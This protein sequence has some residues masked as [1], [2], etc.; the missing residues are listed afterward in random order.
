MELFSDGHCRATGAWLAPL[1]PWL[2]ALNVSCANTCTSLFVCLQDKRQIAVYSRIPPKASLPWSWANPEFVPRVKLHLFDGRK[3]N[4][5][6]GHI[7][8]LSCRLALYQTSTLGE[9]MDNPLEGFRRIGQGLADRKATS[10]FFALRT[11]IRAPDFLT[12]HHTTATGSGTA[13]V[14]TVARVSQATSDLAFRAVC[15]MRTYQW[16]EEVP[17]ARNRLQSEVELVT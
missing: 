8:V 5:G 7:V 10:P 14:L 15:G 9:L 12:T 3:R 1:R 6:G 2:H 4:G 17:G 16:N 11:R 13:V